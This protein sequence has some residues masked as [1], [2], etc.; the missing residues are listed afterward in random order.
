M[1]LESV[2]DLGQVHEEVR[3]AYAPFEIAQYYAPSPHR[4][5][6]EFQ[7]AGDVFNTQQL[8]A[9]GEGILHLQA[10]I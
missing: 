5:R 9:P 10:S 4:N 7:V 3:A 2:A 1:G 8:F 6:A